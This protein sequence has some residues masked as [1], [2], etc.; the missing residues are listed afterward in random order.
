[1]GGIAVKGSIEVL[2]DI[3]ELEASLAFRPD[4][5][6]REWTVE[7]LAAETTKRGLSSVG[8]QVLEAFL[9]K[10]SSSPKGLRGVIARGV[11]PE[12]AQAEAAD[13]ADEPVPEDL[14]DSIEEKI[15]SAPPP[16]FLSAEGRAPDPDRARVLGYSYVER[17]RKIGTLSASKPGR[18]GRSVLGRDLPASRPSVPA[19]IL[20]PSI[21]KAGRDLI[22]GRNGILRHGEGWADILQVRLRRCEVSRTAD[23]SDVLLQYDPGE[24]GYR[25]TDASVVLER[26]V[27]LGWE[28]TEL[29]GADELGAILRGAADIPLVNF[30]LKKKQDSS[31]DLFVA[32]DKSKATVSLRKAKGRG[33]PIDLNELGAMIKASGVKLRDP[34]RFKEDMLAFVKGP[35]EELKDYL[36]AEGRPPGKDKDRT[37][38]LAATVLPSDELAKVRE[39]LSACQSSLEA[40][41]GLDEYPLMSFQK[42]CSVEAGKPVLTLSKAEPGEQGF[43]IFGKIVPS[44]PGIVPTVKCYDGLRFFLDS[45]SSLLTGVML[46]RE[47]DGAVSLRALEYRDAEA[48]ASVDPGGMSARLFLFKG[49][50]IGKPLTLDTAKAALS[51]AG[52][53]FGVDEAAVQAA[54][55][56]ANA[57]KDGDRVE[58]EVAKGKPPRAPKSRAVEWRIQLASGKGVT[59]SATG[60]ADFRNQ[61]RITVVAEGDLIAVVEKQEDQGEPGSDV[62]GKRL[63]PG[64]AESGGIPGHDA[65]V[66]EETD[67]EGYV[68]LVAAK[69]GELHFD[70]NQLFIT[71]AFSVKGDV[72]MKT[73][74]LRFPG[75]VSVSG[76][77]ASGFQLVAGGD[78]TIGEGVE[79]AIVSADGAVRLAQGIRGRGK[80][81]IRARKGMEILF[82]ENAT[83][84]SVEDIKVRNA[85]MAC[86]VMTNGKL[87]LL[88][89]KGKLIGGCVKARNGVD[90]QNLGSESNIKTEVSFGQDY[91]VYQQREAES[92]EIEKVK[93]ALLDYEKRIKEAE[94]SGGAGLAELAQAKVKLL[95]I[96]EKRSVRFWTLDDKF[97]AHFASEIRVRGSVFPGVVL[98]SHNRFLEIT[99]KKSKVVFIFDPTVGKI[100]ESVLPAGH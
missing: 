52:I 81:A 20:D 44:I 42:A 99:E 15:K 30:S 4:P 6:G 86:H 33:K 65:S 92:R 39:R 72:G 75:N 27:G 79:D 84:L 97:E 32:E 45:A 17:G 47:E 71:Q 91:L 26:A 29:L 49:L 11:P 35:Q 23:G 3:A 69:S 53:S 25:E 18:N 87:L 94:R 14:K 66:R 61:D 22:A 8:R 100:V 36:I 9:A 80:G 85:C 62:T 93:L 54:V 16:A 58:R 78:V 10:A 73:G 43:D 56:E 90:V 48:E 46:Y 88:T 40:L 63:D 41:A 76:S 51:A 82:A 59:L 83:L 13:W 67:P 68:K 24:S 95:K 34:E 12:P 37:L 96:L 5:Q 60:K 64:G 89:E 38:T 31:M 98:E 55:D 21:S 74:N 50:G 7:S 28:E 77:V 2:I 1:M 57:S 19:L 70:K